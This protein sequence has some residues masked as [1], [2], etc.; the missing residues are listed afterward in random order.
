[1]PTEPSTGESE[2]NDWRERGALA[3]GH[4]GGLLPAYTPTVIAITFTATEGLAFA[5]A[6]WLSIGI[7]LALVMGR[8]G[9]GAFQWLLLGAVLGP[10]ALPL[11]LARIRDERRPQTQEL[12]AGVRGSG[13]IDVLVGIDGSPE[14]QAALGSAVELLGPRIGRLTLAWVTEFD[15]TSAQ[16]REN[17]KRAVESLERSAEAANVTEPGMVL[18]SGR[19]ADALTDQARHEGYQLLVVGRRGRGATKALLGSTAS[20]LARTDVPVLIV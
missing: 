14:S 18:L 13:A 5:I 4:G 19:P 15:D 11:A 12:A 20:R 16:A 8:R 6:V 3:A 9:H 1:M 2:C 17:T 10:I 7:S